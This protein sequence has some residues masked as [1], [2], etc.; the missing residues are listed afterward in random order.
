MAYGMRISDCSSDVCS[1]D[2]AF[3]ASHGDSLIPWCTERRRRIR[4]RDA[5]GDA[6]QAV[7]VVDGKTERD[8]AAARQTDEMGAFDLEGIQHSDH[9]GLEIG[10]TLE[11]RRRITDGVIARVIPGFVQEEI[12]RLTVRERMCQYV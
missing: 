10:E 2:L 7:R 6:V 1:S 11:C 5:D 8:H 4:P 12:G 3:G 9:I